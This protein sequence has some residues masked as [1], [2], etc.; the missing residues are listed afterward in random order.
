MNAVR[1]AHRLRAMVSASSSPG[2]GRRGLGW[3]GRRHRGAPAQA[4]AKDGQGLSRRR[5]VCLAADTWHPD[6]RHHSLAKLVGQWAGTE[7][8]DVV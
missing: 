8:G 7:E 2:L 6:A 4:A 3:R 1:R 5:A